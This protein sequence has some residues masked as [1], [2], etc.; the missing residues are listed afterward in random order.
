MQDSHLFQYTACTTDLHGSF[1]T[2]RVPN[3]PSLPVVDV[4]RCAGGLVDGLAL[5]RALPVANLLY[6]PVA[7]PHHLLHRLLPECDLALLLKVLLTGLLLRRLEVGNIGVVAL[8]NV[9][10]CAFQ[11]RVFG[12]SLD[13]F[14]LHNA[15][16]PIRKPNGKN[17]LKK[18][19]SENFETWLLG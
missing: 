10:V 1:F 14:F 5:V 13:T 6:R 16:P 4:L 12:K 7:L 15:Q 3:E 2:A 17:C 8:L 18:Q 9:L 19:K 11:D